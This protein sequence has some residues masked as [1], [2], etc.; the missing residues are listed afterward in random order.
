MVKYDVFE[1]LGPIIGVPD[2][3]NRPETYAKILQ[4]IGLKDKHEDAYQKFQAFLLLMKKW[5]TY[6]KT[7][8]NVRQKYDPQQYRLPKSFTTVIPA[9]DL[10]EKYKDSLPLTTSLPSKSTPTTE[11][12]PI[13]VVQAVEAEKALVAVE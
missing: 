3:Y 11:V 1:K 4:Y 7:V 8:A 2:E 9:T 6:C 13:V 12:D 5:E 10:Y